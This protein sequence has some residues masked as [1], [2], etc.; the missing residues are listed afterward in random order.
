MSLTPPP[1]YTSA[2]LCGCAGVCAA[3]IVVSL[4]SD[5]SAPVGDNIHRLPHGGSYKDGTKSVVY[6]GRFFEGKGHLGLEED[7]NNFWV[8]TVV[9]LLI[10]LIYVSHKC[11]SRNR[12]FHY[13]N[14][15]FHPTPQ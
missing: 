12:S 5:Y 13:H 2:V 10:F 7:F 9:W 1:N 15:A 11:T 4:K 6:A 8:F 14:C 3:L